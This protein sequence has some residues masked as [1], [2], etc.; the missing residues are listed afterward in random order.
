VDSDSYSKIEKG[1]PAWMELEIS[2]G[3]EIGR[4]RR[5]RRSSRNFDSVF[6]CWRR[7]LY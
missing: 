4:E 1:R 6:F 2:T 7:I 3:I 5:R